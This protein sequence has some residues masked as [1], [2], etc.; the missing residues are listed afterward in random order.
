MREYYEQ[1]IALDP[2]YAPAY[3]G[4][5]LYHSW[6]APSGIFSPDH[7][8]LAEEAVR[9]AL[10]LDENALAAEVYYKR[11][12]PAAERAFHRGMELDPSF[13]DL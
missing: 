4:L 12:W 7:W 11:D 10:T 2:S 5:S 13:G 1:T 6:A 8:P 3:V 9:K